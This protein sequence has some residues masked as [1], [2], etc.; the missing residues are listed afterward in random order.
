MRKHI[1]QELLKNDDSQIVI[2]LIEK[3]YNKLWNSNKTIQASLLSIDFINF[4]KKGKIEQAIE[5]LRM[6]SFSQPE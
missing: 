5:V 3:N 4:L 6:P 1:R 2:K